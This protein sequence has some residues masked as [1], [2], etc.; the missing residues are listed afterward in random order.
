MGVLAGYLAA[1]L[2]LSFYARRRIGAK[3]WRKLHRATLAVWGLALAHTLGAGSDAGA[4]WLRAVVLV[5]AVPIAHLTVLRVLGSRR[6]RAAA[7]L[8]GPAARDAR[9]G[10]QAERRYLHRRQQ[11]LG[12]PAVL[13]DRRRREDRPDRACRARGSRA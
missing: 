11:R 9:R 2:G 4:L 5:P 12:H 8:A 10:A 7:R 13:A 6:A 3:R 1:I